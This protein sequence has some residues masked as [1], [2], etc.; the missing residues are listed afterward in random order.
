MDIVP[1]K[2]TFWKSISVV[3]FIFIV[4]VGY[5]VQITTEH[6][7]AEDT[8]K[9]PQITF[10]VTRTLLDVIAFVATFCFFILIWRSTMSG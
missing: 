7:F 4:Q 10:L 2:L 5:L 6:F 9:G 8:L 1:I 3:G